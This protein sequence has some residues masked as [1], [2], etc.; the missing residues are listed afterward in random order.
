MLWF[1]FSEIDKRDYFKEAFLFKE[2]SRS[3]SRIKSN[4]INNSESVGVY[5]GYT[6]KK[7]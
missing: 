1:G 7:S 5:I 2:S 4:N 6:R 3:G